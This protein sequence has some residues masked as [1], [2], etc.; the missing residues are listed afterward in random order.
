VAA[1]N[2]CVV[3]AN[4]KIIAVTHVNSLIITFARATFRFAAFD[5]CT[6]TELS[7]RQKRVFVKAAAP[8]FRQSQFL[9]G[10]KLAVDL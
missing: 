5:W 8:D 6:V 9:K 4:S 7:V 10:A 1:A 3:G 2:E